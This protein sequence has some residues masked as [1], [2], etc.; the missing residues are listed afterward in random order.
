MGGQYGVQESIDMGVFVAELG[1][2][3]GDSLVDGKF[4]F[5][6]D[7]GNFTPALL[8]LVPA[9]QGA[10]MI[11]KE[12]GELDA[13]DKAEFQTAMENSFNIPQARTE[14]F[15]EDTLSLALTGTRQISLHG[16]ITKYFTGPDRI[17][18]K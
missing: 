15:V 8:K 10:G 6:Q 3:V 7:I 4:S 1:N 12:V 14:E 13:E 11:P 5:L 18:K 2:G 16:Y 17:F 9:V